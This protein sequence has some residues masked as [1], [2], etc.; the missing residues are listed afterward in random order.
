MIIAENRDIDER[1]V[2]SST[3]TSAQKDQGGVIRSQ[4]A[5][6]ARGEKEISKKEAIQLLVKK[7]REAGARTL[8]SAQRL[9]KE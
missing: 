3:R 1:G 6:G 9:K 8:A 5:I 7:A 4:T 2:G